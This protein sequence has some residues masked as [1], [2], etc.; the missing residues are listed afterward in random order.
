MKQ[1]DVIYEA[2]DDVLAA[3]ARTKA[4]KGVQIKLRDQ[5]LTRCVMPI[6]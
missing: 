1:I 6:W 3:W 2:M 4:A 5:L